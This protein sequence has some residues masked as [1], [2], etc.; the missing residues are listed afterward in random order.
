MKIVDVR[1]KLVRDRTHIS[2][3]TNK[4]AV[5]LS[6]VSRHSFSKACAVLSFWKQAYAL[7]R[8]PVSG[9]GGGFRQDTGMSV[10]W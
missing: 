7:L 8:L 5:Y 4:W 6:T 3:F 2:S 9:E 10:L 1:F